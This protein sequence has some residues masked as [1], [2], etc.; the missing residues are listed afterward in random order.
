MFTLQ[1]EDI[2]LTPDAPDGRKWIG[3]PVVTATTPKAGRIVSSPATWLVATKGACA[4]VIFYGRYT[5]PQKNSS[6]SI[7]ERMRVAVADRLKPHGY[8]VE[9]RQLGFTF[10]PH[11]CSDYV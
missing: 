9:T 6:E 7:M 2:W 5:S 4:W 11:N 8:S 3:M 1:G 10:L